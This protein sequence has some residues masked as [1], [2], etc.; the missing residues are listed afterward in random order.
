MKSETTTVFYPLSALRN[1]FF[2][3]I[4]SVFAGITS[5]IYLFWL[6]MDWAIS[7]DGEEKAFTTWINTNASL[8]VTGYLLISF[9]LMI[10]AAILVVFYVRTM[11]FQISEKEV[12]VK[13]GIINKT[14]KHVPF[15]TITNVSSRYGIYDRLF[16]IGTVEIETAGKSGQQTGPEEKI[17][18]IDN[19]FEVRDHILDVLRQF[20]HQYATGTEV[21]ESLEPVT[22]ERP[23]EKALLDELREIKEIL[24]K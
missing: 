18:G 5:A 2:L 1:K 16:G 13:K 24:K 10:I 11:E 15:R 22:L 23:L 17:E 12:I 4:I 19:Y 9:I 8:L 20:R 14:E 21:P 3:Y 7:I 6:F